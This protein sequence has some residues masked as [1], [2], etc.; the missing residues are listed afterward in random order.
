M[1]RVKEYYETAVR[2]LALP[3]M[4]QYI[5]GTSFHLMK[6]EEFMLNQD[7]IPDIIFMRVVEK[8]RYAEF[9]DLV[10]NYKEFKASNATNK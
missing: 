8:K 4:A 5:I 2:F 7:S 9:R 6:Y 3:P 1:N 10:V